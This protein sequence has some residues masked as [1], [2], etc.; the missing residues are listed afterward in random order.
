MTRRSRNTRK[1]RQITA[2]VAASTFI[3]QNVAWAACADGTLFPAGGFIVGQAPVA[4]P[5]AFSPGI[6]TGTAGSIFVPD[7][8]VCEDN[9]CLHKPQ[10]GGGHNWAFDQGSTL[11]KVVDTGPPGGPATGWALA[12]NSPSVSIVLPII[13]GG[14]VTNLGDVP[15]QGQVITPTCNPGLLSAAGVPNKANTYFNQLGCS[16]SHGVANDAHSA[17]SF[18]FVAGIKGGLFYIPL[19]NVKNPTTGGPAGK[20]AGAINY[21]SDIPEGQKLTNAAVSPDGMFAMATSIRRA[22]PIYACLNPLGDP[23]DPSQPINPNFFVPPAAQAKCMQIGNNGLAVDLTTDFG[24]DN[25]P[26]FGGQRVVNT[27]NATPGSNA[28]NPVPSAWPQ[29]IIQNVGGLTGTFAQ[30]LQTVFNNHS[31]GHCGNATA[32]GGFTAALITQPQAILPH[33]TVN[34]DKYMYAGPLGGTVVQFKISIDPFSGLT[35]Y[36]FRTYLTGVALTT[37]LGVA[38]DLGS[39]I[40]MNDPTAVGLAGQER[41]TK[42][43]LCEDMQ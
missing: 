13:K 32:N 30:Q 23:G 9:D 38:D 7:N 28:L 10:T 6:F 36:N 22:Q 15:L 14:R 25:Q 16:I 41:M 20:L 2:L 12:P 33:T 18:L 1:L 35:Q 24:P 17:T 40:V 27:F 26:Y 8:S 5:N 43:P 4:D 29:C 21:Y 3:N 19:D 31:A 34:G 37:G 11:N 42:V 39:L